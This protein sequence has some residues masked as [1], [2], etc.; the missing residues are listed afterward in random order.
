M[1]SGLAIFGGFVLFDTGLEPSMHLSF[2]LLD[3]APNCLSSSDTLEKL[4][5]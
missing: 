3:E 1:Y 5:Q 4:V 2:D